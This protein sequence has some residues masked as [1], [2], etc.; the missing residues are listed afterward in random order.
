VSIPGIDKIEEQGELMPY[1]IAWELLSKPTLELTDEQLLL[2]AND[3]R[4]KRKRFLQ[5]QAD[6]AGS[7]KSIKAPAATAEEKKARTEH[8]KTQLK[9]DG[10][11]F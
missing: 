8:L 2:I 9:L 5:G 10:L 4:A 1:G 3:L 11:Q 7:K 6:T